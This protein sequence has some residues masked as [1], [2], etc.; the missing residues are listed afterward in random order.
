MYVCI[1]NLKEEGALYMSFKNPDK[2]KK[3]KPVYKKPTPKAT[4][5]NYDDVKE[6]WEKKPK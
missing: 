5:K 1:Q 4:P 2:L 6:G 3:K